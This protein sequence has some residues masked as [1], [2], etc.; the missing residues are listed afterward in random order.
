LTDKPEDCV[1]YGNPPKHTRFRKGGP[2]PK[3][4]KKGPVT[5]DV[6]ALLSEPVTVGEGRD[7]RKMHVY[8]VG[9]RRQVSPAL[10]GCLR[11]IALLMQEFHAHGVIEAKTTG[12]EWPAVLYKPYDYDSDEWERNLK[13]YGPPPWPLEHDG[14]SRLQE[15]R[16]AAGR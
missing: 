12:S 3:R 13:R 16:N 6:H 15:L 11:S 2:Q 1:G 5:I 8:E 14:L 4:R 7:A 9:L 10:K